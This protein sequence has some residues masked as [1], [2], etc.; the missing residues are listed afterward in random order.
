MK[1][2]ID[3]PPGYDGI[4]NIAK[5][6][7]SVAHHA[8]DKRPSSRAILAFATR[9][10][11][12]WKSIVTLTQ[13]HLDQDSFRAI[14][15][16]CKAI[17]RCM[18][19]AYLQM[20]WIAEGPNNSDDMG[21]LYLD[22]GPVERYRLVELILT[23]DDGMSR[24]LANSPRKQEGHARLK[25]EFDKVK[26]KYLKS[27]GRGVCKQWYEGSLDSIAKD[28]HLSGEYTWLVRTNNS[29]VHTG[30]SAMFRVLDLA[31]R[32]IELLSESIMMRGLEV[33]SK[34]YKLNLTGFT[35]EVIEA[36]V[37]FTLV[38]FTES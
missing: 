24:R 1:N 38:Q 13:H 4:L 19:D 35:K 37:K 17:Q 32:T 10:A 6:V 20:K 36:Y 22:F 9:L 15:N 2:I 33:L 30:P 26:H 28:L 14:S 21:Q 8:K 34:H 12:S 5:E 3:D 31:A 7:I 25:E 18:Y 11:G 23:L 27:N 29:S 16:D